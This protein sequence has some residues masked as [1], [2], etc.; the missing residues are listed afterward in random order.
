MIADLAR[1]LEISQTVLFGGF[2]VFLRVG[3][4]MAL[5]PAFGEAFIP[6]RVRLAASIAFAMIVWPAMRDRLADPAIAATPLAVLMMVEILAGLVLGLAF[7]LIVM[8]LQFAAAIA[9]Q[10]TSLSQMFG[11]GATPDPMP[12]LG[13]IL[14]LAALVIAVVSGL[15]VK[16]VQAIWASYA[17]LPAGKVPD[18]GDL[19]HWLVARFGLAMQLTFS[20]AAPFVAASLA[21][22]LAFGAINRA[23]PA[24][25]VAFIGAPLLTFGSLLLLMLS[26]PVLLQVWIAAFDQALAMPLE[27]RG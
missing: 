1:L 27:T 5:L 7:R 11:A 6:V 10:S 3:A 22:N 2:L 9:A 23:M 4:V 17:V 8:A 16:V 19:A 24:L 18:P 15:H 13:N 25:A 20:L 12:A 26:A 21:V 14:V